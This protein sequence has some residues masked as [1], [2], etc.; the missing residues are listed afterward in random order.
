MDGRRPSQ[1]NMGL[2]NCVHTQVTMNASPAPPTYP[3]DN[4]PTHCRVATH[5]LPEGGNNGFVYAI[6]KG[7]VD[8][9]LLY[10]EFAGYYRWV[11]TESGVVRKKINFGEFGGQVSRRRL[12]SFFFF[13]LS[14]CFVHLDRERKRNT[15]LRRLTH[16][17]P[18][19]RSKKVPK[20]L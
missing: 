10:N 12:F 5:R 19:R 16:A 8:G 20:S 7:V 15:H 1:Y 14:L 9:G 2:D 6:Y 4:P 17:G 18:N 11:Y 3:D 13:F